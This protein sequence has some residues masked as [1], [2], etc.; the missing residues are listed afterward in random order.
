[1]AVL[2]ATRKT[3]HIGLPF[4]DSKSSLTTL[5]LLSNSLSAST[6]YVGWTEKCLNAFWCQAPSFNS[7]VYFVTTKLLAFLE[8][9]A[10]VENQC[11]G[12]F[13][14]QGQYYTTLRDSLS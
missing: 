10:K 5:L 9:I 6:G 4:S 12:I 8:Y 7:E 14:P 1:M 13:Y 11:Y 2:L 3:K